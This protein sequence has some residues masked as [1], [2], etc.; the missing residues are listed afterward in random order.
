MPAFHVSVNFDVEGPYCVAYPGPAQLY[1]VLDE[2]RTALADGRIDVAL[3]GGVA[4]QSN[5]LVRH[6]FSRIL[7]PTPADKL[8]DLGAFVVLETETSARR[9][10]APIRARLESVQLAYEPPDVLHVPQASSER[11]LVTAL[12][13]AHVD[14][15]TLRGVAEYS[16]GPGLLP[17]ALDVAVHAR[18][19]GGGVFKHMLAS[20]DGVRAESVWVLP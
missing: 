8:R 15:D 19:D 1:G 18:R 14:R 10:E 2:A 9:R 16:L 20:R 13:G 4:A 6:H 5:F 12:D 17:F 3:V 11:V 7:P